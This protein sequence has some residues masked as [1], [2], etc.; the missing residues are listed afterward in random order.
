MHLQQDGADMGVIY[1]QHGNAIRVAHTDR[2][3]GRMTFET[4]ED[5]EPTVES[6]KL[7]REN[8]NPKAMMRHVAR[9][10]M[11]VYEQA[12]REGW[13]EDQAAW[14]RWLNDPDNKAF[15]VWE[16]TV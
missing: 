1:D 2:A 14:T 3:D 4:I 10:P 5:H 13:A 12:M 7:L 15:R 9:V 11:V 6:A 8:A 16:G